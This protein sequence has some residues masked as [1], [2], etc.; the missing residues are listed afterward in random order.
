LVSR[1]SRFRACLCF[2]IALT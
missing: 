1:L 2:L